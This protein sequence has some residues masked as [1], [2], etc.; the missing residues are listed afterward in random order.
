MERLAAATSASPTSR[1]GR[2]LRDRSASTRTSATALAISLS[3]QKRRGAS[4][5]AVS[6]SV[7]ARAA[8]ACEP[9][10]P[11]VDFGVLNVQADYLAAQIDAV[12]RTLLEGIIVTGIVMLLLP[13]VVAQ[14]DRRADRDPVLALRHAYDS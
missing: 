7:L 4:E 14:R 10:Y 11:A 9:Q 2:R 1:R 3:V 13:A 8:A 5:V 12:L 6:D